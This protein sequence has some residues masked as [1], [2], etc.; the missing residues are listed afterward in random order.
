MLVLFMA[1]GLVSAMDLNNTGDST[2]LL[3][4]DV[5][6]SQD[7]IVSND[8]ILNRN[9]N[10]NEFSFGDVQE[11][12]KQTF[13]SGNDTELYFRNG[14][15]FKVILSDSGGQPL[16]NQNIIF[17]INGNNYT[18]IT[19]ANGIASITI[20]L[21]SGSYNISSLYQGSENYESSFIANT[22]NVLS[23]IDG[24]DIEKYYK[25]DTQYY[26]TFFDGRN[27]LLRDTTVTFNI[28]GVLYQ[29]K[30]NENGIAKLN[31]NLLP[32]TYILTATNPINGE[33][34]SNNITV[35]SSIIASDI[36][37]YYKNDTQYCVNVLDGAGNPLT[38]GSITFNINGVFYTRIINEN[39]VAKLNINLSPG[40]YIITAT[41][42]INGEMH[43]N[44]I[45]V[46]PTIDTK[47]LTMNYRDGGK[48]TA[49]ALDDVGNPLANSEITFNIN[50][51]FYTRVTNNE[52]N[53]NLN[54]NLNVGEYII[55]STNHKGLSVSNRI[56]ITKSHATI[57]DSNIH[58]I[59][60]LNREYTITLIGLNNKTIPSAAINFKY[61][62]I[63]V[64]AVTNENGEATIVIPNLHEGK[65][66]IE[67]E[68]KGNMNYYSYKSSNT[69]IIDN[70]TNIL[71][72]KDLKMTYKD[73]SK[74][75]VIL[76]DLKSI[77]LAN[78]SITFYVCGKQ[79]SR[80]TNENGV[81]SLDINLLPG[82]YEISYTYSDVD[83]VNYNKGSK[84]IAVS[85]IPAYFSTNDLAFEHGDSKAFTAILTDGDKAP[86]S[87]VEVTFDIFGVSYHRTTNASGVAKLNINLPVGYYDI[88][89]SLD[90]PFYSAMSKSNHVLVN[91]SIL[92]GDDLSLIPGLTRDFSV[93]LLDAY[94]NPISNAV[95]EFSYN[96]ITKRAN[97][98]AQGVAT[99]AVG[100]L[101]LGEYVVVYKYIKGDNAA[102]S[103]ILV[104]NSVLNSK[105]TIS[106][107]NPYLSSSKNCPVSNS[108]I[109]ALAKQLTGGLTNP[110]DKAIAIYD[111]V[112]DQI[113]YSYYYDTYYGAV[114]T[115][116]AKRGNCVDQSHLSIAL[117][118][119]AG[120]PARYVHGTCV[121]GDG[122][123][124]GHVWTQVLVDDI[125]IVS[126]SINRRN[127][128]GNVVNW[129]NYNYKLNGYFSYIY[130]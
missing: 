130:L 52:G 70:A 116:H 34:S 105:N 122:Y 73:G 76:T 106:N 117:Y 120:L 100:N 114:G 29:R 25:N 36:V 2:Y 65:Y 21:R 47:D 49:H 88:A 15:A 11:G 27:N 24:G 101:A 60:G 96:G 30:T 82:N 121:F 107:L 44:N 17:T 110:L 128:L 104:S 77:P 69:L 92:T 75:N 16:A 86:L 72:G 91:G 43:S 42:P 67:Y 111:Y 61:D 112:R 113:S 87:G 62:G 8:S 71:S 45:R 119:A 125:W 57:K 54:I 41:N 55:T 53:A 9:I 126:D 38:A 12:M 99:V 85:K 115:L 37:K 94:R 23:T 48:F 32:G 18:R 95:I 66:S 39:A 14:T 83:D 89:T 93:T 31:I 102:Q 22:V 109:V 81:A 20:N 50:G 98:N 64:D 46:L 40:N 58:G 97:T 74:F 35:L 103:N 33:M 124:G 108:E 84:N 4:H 80:I 5:S 79:Y 90:S 3:N 26:A 1:M 7:L 19:N 68:F 10:D 123:S 56:F 28:N 127:S 13:L 59:S 6:F 51:V 129:N 118:R 63:S 78:E